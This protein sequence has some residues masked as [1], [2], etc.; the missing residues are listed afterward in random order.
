MCVCASVRAR[1]RACVRACVRECVCV[2][3]CVRMCV[4][5]YVCVCVSECKCVGLCM[6]QKIGKFS[7]SQN[8]DE[9]CRSE[10]V[11]KKCPVEFL[12]P[13]FRFVLDKQTN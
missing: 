8:R 13:A 3:A 2:C 9:I 11:W 4:C 12:F 10:S 7:K 6:Y 1:A 5:A